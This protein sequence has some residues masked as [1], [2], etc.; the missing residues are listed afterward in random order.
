MTKKF[1]ETKEETTDSGYRGNT[2]G[3]ANLG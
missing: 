2:M 1:P 3:E